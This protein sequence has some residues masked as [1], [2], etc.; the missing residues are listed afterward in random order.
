MVKD[1]NIRVFS[2]QNIEK[3]AMEKHDSESILISIGT[4]KGE[5]ARVESNTI[6]NIRAIKFLDFADLDSESQGYK[7]INK[8][9][10]KDIVDFVE[11][12]TNTYNIKNVFVN[13]EAG[14]SRSAG[15]AGALMKFYI[16]DDTKIFK[17][18]RYMPNMKCYTMI[19]RELYSRLK[20]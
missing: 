20:D 13:C 19:L 14:I 4:V 7:I 15:V 8:H 17:N 5:S 3:Y 1:L 16:G 12:Y 11:Y 2:K 10:A 9:I 6:N 18:P